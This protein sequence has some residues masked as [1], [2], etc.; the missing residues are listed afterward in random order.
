MTETD[1]PEAAPDDT[2][3]TKDR[4]SKIVLVLATVL[5]VVSVLGVWVKTQA[6]DTDEW[7]RMSSDLL[8]EPEV[9]ESLAAYLV[10]QL[11]DSIDVSTDVGERLPESLEGIAPTLVAA[12]RGPITD[13]VERLVASDAFASAWANINRTA[14]STLVAILRDETRPG[15]STADGTVTLE[16]R[17]LLIVVGD[18]L[19]FSGDRLDALPDDAGS[20]VIFE[21]DELDAVQQGVK[22]VDFLSWFL[23]VLVLALYALSVALARE[24]WLAA[25]RWVGVAIAV[26]GVVILLLRAIAVDRIVEAVVQDPANMPLADVVA[27]NVTLLIRQMAWSA[28]VWGVVIA[29]FTWLLGGHRVAVRFRGLI[30]PIMSASIATVVGATVVL[31]L[32]LLWWNPG[33]T[34]D[35]AFNSIVTIALVIGAMIALHRQ[36]AI[37]A[38]RG[39]DADAVVDEVDVD[40]GSEADEPA[41]TS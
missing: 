11:Y 35:G 12:L 31:V 25:L 32:A 17:E 29:L 10:D 9:Q 23:F 36:V 38:V 6:L 39:G 3:G 8:D 7:V 40:D 41:T 34:F 4:T 26:G 5:M 13:G 2:S 19:G 20:I 24:R 16:L 1:S 14:H 21:S 27:A 15:I 30:A 18:A 37:D 28:V 33:R 22:V